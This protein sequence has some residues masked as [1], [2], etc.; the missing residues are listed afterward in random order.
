LVL[1]ARISFSIGLGPVPAIW[2][3]E[4]LPASV[5]TNAMGLAS[6]VNWL[7]NGVVTMSFLPLV[8]WEQRVVWGENDD[9]DEMNGGRLVFIYWMYACLLIFGALFVYLFCPETAGRELD[10]DKL[11]AGE[12]QLNYSSTAYPNPH[13]DNQCGIIC[14]HD[15][16]GGSS[17]GIR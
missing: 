15:H 2:S 11:P 4:L 1:L 14:P 7:T 13:H 6:T 3:P 16:I 9:D 12:N 10:D 17:R 8:R 5:R